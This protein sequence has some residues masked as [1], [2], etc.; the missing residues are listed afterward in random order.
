[1]P[2]SPKIPAYSHH[3]PSGRAVVKV[4]GDRPGQR[5]SIYLGPY[6]SDESRENYARV[7]A[8]LLAGRQ[9]TPTS[10]ATRGTI[11]PVPSF[12]V[13][14]LVSRY[15]L[16]ARAYYVKGGRTTSEVYIVTAA[17]Q[18]LLSSHSGLP[19]DAFSVGDLRVVRDAMVATGQSRQTVNRYV[20]IIVRMY[21]WGTAEQLVS[22][23]TWSALR[24]LPW[25][26]AGRTKARDPDPIK[27]VDDKV[28]DDTLVELGPIVKAMVELQR[29][30]GMRPNEVCQLRRMDLDRSGDVWRYVPQEHKTQHHGKQRVILIGPKG[31]AVL[32]PFLVRPADEYCFRPARHIAIP[33]KLKRYRVDSYRNAVWRACDRAFPAPEGTTGAKLTA[34]RKSHR[35][36]PNR[37]RHSFAT[38]ARAAYGLEAVQV[39]LGH[40]S[41]DVSQIYAETNTARGVEVIRM[42]G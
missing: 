5:R 41:A 36:S 22:A 32:L 1:M 27:P 6:G 19:A 38:Q 9:L 8:D 2:R 18:F 40:S 16:H 4:P 29:A 25:L 20:G 17:T 26:K 21:R 13:A 15:R 11:T 12:T 33:R 10:S 23:A 37:L 31:Q 42:I 7:V 39:L 35:W 34:W 28:V 24:A 14:E 30:T 3:K